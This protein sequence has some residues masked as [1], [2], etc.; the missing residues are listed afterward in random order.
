LSS[1]EFKQGLVQ[2]EAGA[3]RQRTAVMCAEALWWRCHRRLLA[4][5]LLGR[6]WLVSHIGSRGEVSEHVLTDFARVDGTRVTYPASGTD[7]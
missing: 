6:G 1:A 2:L 7:E 4:D 3:R 5:V